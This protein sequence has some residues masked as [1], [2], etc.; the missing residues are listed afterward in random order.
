MS[1]ITAL[2]PSLKQWPF[3]CICMK[4]KKYQTER[5]SMRRYLYEIVDS[6]D[7]IAGIYL[8]AK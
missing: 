2:L 8:K 3:R 4:Q 7:T 1:L 5:I 6:D